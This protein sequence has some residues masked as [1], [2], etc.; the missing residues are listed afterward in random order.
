M[1]PQSYECHVTIDPVLDEGRLQ[2]LVLLAKLYGFKVARLLMEKGPST[3]D[4]FLT[5]HSRD[6]NL[7]LNN[8]LRMLN[9]LRESTFT[10]RRYKIEGIFLDSKINDTF[11]QI[12]D[13]S[14]D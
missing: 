3:R 11:G 9:D 12:L 6:Y 4:S 8:M 13:G 2:A 5:G 1:S 14:S 10:V 7:L